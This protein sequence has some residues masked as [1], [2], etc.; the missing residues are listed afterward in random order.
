MGTWGI[1]PLIL[2]LGAISGNCQ[3][4]VP[5]ATVAP[6]VWGPRTALAARDISGG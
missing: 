5:V 4:Y 3:Q 6:N 2:N 1:A